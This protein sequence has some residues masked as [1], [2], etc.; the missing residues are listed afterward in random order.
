MAGIYIHI[1]FCKQACHYCDF[2]FSTQLKQKESFLQALQKEIG[3]R[4]S[5]LGQ[6]TVDTI[7]LGGGTPSLLDAQELE[8]L[9]SSLR[10]QF[11]ISGNAE[12]TLE[13]NPDDLTP[14]K[15]SA[16]QRSAVNRLSIGIQS[17]REE[18][19][20][21]MNR[22]HTAAQ[23]LQCVRLARDHGIRNI[24]IDLMY[25]L[26]GLDDVSWK[27]NIL[28]AVEMEVE[29]ISAYCLTVEPRTALAGF[30]QKGITSIPDDAC[31][32]GHF[33]ILREITGLY[34]YK[35]YE[36]SN[37]A[38]EGYVS[39]HNSNY[40]KGVS[41]LGLGPSA[42]SFDGQSRQWNVSNNTKYIQALLNDTP[43][44]QKEDLTPEQRYNEYVMTSL[45]TMWGCDT[46]VIQG[47]FGAKMETHFLKEAEFYLHSGQ[48]VK[49]NE[50][51][52]LTE[53]GMLIAD[54]IASDLFIV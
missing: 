17:Y 42:H 6:Q 14:E 11:V 31:S 51:L 19:L 38:K 3:L 13:A 27:E 5:Y 36:I 8:T 53:E 26:P 25:G 30:I 18:D 35:Q 34:N 20:Q 45:R 52:I 28:Q 46:K 22:A 12:I 23:A 7:Y 15:L 2:H 33:R 16:I 24:S 1:P 47:R 37:F 9:F 54:K 40:W 43:D 41:Y 48:L 50:V 21:R 39:K 29:H 49:I 32:A 10:C 44:F 4:K